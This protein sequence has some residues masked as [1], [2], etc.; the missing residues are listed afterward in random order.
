MDFH[1]AEDWLL[2]FANYEITPLDAAPAARLELQPLRELL[3][4]SGD[5]QQGRRSVHITGSKGKG[6]VATMI[7]A[8]LQASD[9]R[10]GLYTS[11]HLHT[12]RER[13]QVDGAYIPEADF[14]ML[15]SELRTR[16]GGMRQRL[17]TFELLTA[18]AFLYFQRQEVDWQVIEVGLGGALDATNVLDKKQLCVFTPIELEHTAILGNTVAQIATDKAGILRP[19]VRAVMGLQR[20]SAA[21]VLRAACAALSVPLVEVAT[22][23]QMSRGRAGLDGQELHLRTPTAE[24]RLRLPLLGRYQAEN[25]VTAVLAAEQLTAAGLALTPQIAAGALADLRWPGRMELL[26]RRPLVV[27]DGGHTPDAARRIV[28]AV[29]EELPHRAVLL[30]IGLSSDKNAAAFA[31]PFAALDP[32]VTAT[33][34]RHPRAMAAAAVGQA[35]QAQGMIVRLAPSVAAA[36]DAALAEAGAE[37]L[38]LATGSLFVAAEA[39]E[40]VLGITP[41]RP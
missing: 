41:D 35:F 24:Y 28:E 34:S 10:V 37:D 15:T 3:R 25:A 26:K 40:A 9:K 12:I 5:P 13:I 27:V 8:L 33:V 31:A 23:C 1:E 36:I 16:V 30:V 20:E 7:A 4:L 6:S 11:P 22:T 18:L 19:G 17:T 39:R 14:A 21:E 2:G 32:L 38:V 29:R